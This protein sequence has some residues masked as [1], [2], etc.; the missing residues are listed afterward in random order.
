MLKEAVIISAV[1]TAIARNGGALAKIPA[2]HYSA[3][4]IK[5]IIKRSGVPY[6]NINDVILGNVLSG[7][8]NIARLSILETELSV[9]IP[10][11]TIDRQCGSS[12]SA[13]NLAA[14]AIESGRGD[15]YIAGGVESYSQAPY[16]LDKPKK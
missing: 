14:Q 5:E 9:K 8:G 13:I 6:D 3:T 12:I 15:F 16:L 4:V 7:G 10:G 11:L 2:H 1:R